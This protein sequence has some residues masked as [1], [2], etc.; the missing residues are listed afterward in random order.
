[1]FITRIDMIRTGHT[2]AKLF[3]R[4]WSDNFLVGACTNLC[5]LTEPNKL[6]NYKLNQLCQNLTSSHHLPWSPIQNASI[7]LLSMAQESKTSIVCFCLLWML[8]T[9]VMKIQLLWCSNYSDVLGWASSP[10]PTEPSLFK[11]SQSPTLTRAWNGLG[12]GLRFWKP[13]P[14][15]Q[16]QARALVLYLSKSF[17]NLDTSL[18]W[19]SKTWMCAKQPQCLIITSQAT[20]I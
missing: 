7:C 3:G 5:K 15:L 16:A 19:L 20:H 8:M 2:K 11:P 6:A 14:K 18:R 4:I 1:M 13:K 17:L 12:P 10:E 9:M